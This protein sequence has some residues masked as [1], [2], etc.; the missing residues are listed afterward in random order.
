MQ[1]VAESVR[2]HWRHSEYSVKVPA[3]CSLRVKK[4]PTRRVVCLNLHVRKTTLCVQLGIYGSG[5]TYILQHG[6]QLC[7][8]DEA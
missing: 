1:E 8:C 3:S 6:P 7:E 2:V 4:Q 5:N